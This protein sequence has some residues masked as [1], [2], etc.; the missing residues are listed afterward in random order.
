MKERKKTF[1]QVKK[2]LDKMKL[3]FAESKFEDEFAL[4]FDIEG[5]QFLVRIFVLGEWV[6]VAALVV[7]AEFVP[8]GLHR[9]LLKANW[10]LFDVTYSVDEAGNIFSENDIPSASNFENF[11]SEFNA[12]VA[13]VLYFFKAIANEFSVSRRDTYD[14]KVVSVYS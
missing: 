5:T 13:G 7:P 4:P 11:E 10:D 2:W 14:K 1:K 8:E 3:K 12:V 6:K 9:A